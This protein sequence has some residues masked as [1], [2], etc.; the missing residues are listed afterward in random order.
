MIVIQWTGNIISDV[1]FDEVTI[2]YPDAVTTVF[3]YKDRGQ[4]QAVVTEVTDGGSPAK[5][6]SIKRTNS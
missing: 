1:H 4:V 2:A 5:T 6:I 3:T